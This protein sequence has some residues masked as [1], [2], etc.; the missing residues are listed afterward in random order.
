MK[1]QKFQVINWSRSCSWMAETIKIR[2][3]GFRAHRES[4]TK[5]MKHKESKTKHKESK[6][7]QNK[8]PQPSLVTP[9]C[10]TVF[11]WKL[12]NSNFWV[13]LPCQS[14]VHHIWLMASDGW[15]GQS[16]RENSSANV[17]C[18][19]CWWSLFC[20]VLNEELSVAWAIYNEKVWEAGSHTPLHLLLQN[21]LQ[22]RGKAGSEV[23]GRSGDA[24]GEA[25]F[26]FCSGSGSCFSVNA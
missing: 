10:D 7:K 16:T 8:S 25:F 1:K 5:Q 4:K 13:W 24:T 15:S 9:L 11:L 22:S 26:F 12:G 6:T 17:S 3:S 23:K 21:S 20:F 18:F 14:A 19:I 2:H